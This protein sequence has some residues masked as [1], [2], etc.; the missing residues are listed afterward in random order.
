[1]KTLLII[2]YVLLFTA[3]SKSDE[4]KPSVLSSSWKET[5]EYYSIGGPII[6]KQTP[7]ANAEVIEFK[8]NHVFYSSLRPNLNRYDL[9]EADNATEPAKL[10]LYEAGKTDTTYWFLKTVTRDGIE[11]GFSGCIE[12]CGK[13]F[14]RVEAE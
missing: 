3:C 11:I 4:Q 8:E 2:C 1:M 14:V 12:G 6:W 5:E 9:E 7:A 13:R 10:K